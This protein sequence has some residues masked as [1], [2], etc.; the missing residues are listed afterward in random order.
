MENSHFL[1]TVLDY[2][3]QSFNH[4]LKRNNTFQCHRHRLRLD[5]QP[6]ALAAL[7]SILLEAE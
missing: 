7:Y 1:F 3:E 2:E 4:A 6:Q 5:Y